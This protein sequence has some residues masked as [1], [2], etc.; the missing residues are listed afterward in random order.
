[1]KKACPYC[2]KIHE[3]SFVC[4]KKPQRFTQERGS[5]EDRFRWSYDWKLKREH[6]LRRDRYLCRA[7]LARLS[8]TVKPLN[9]KK[10]SVHHIRSLR[11][12]WE[13]RLAD[14]NLISLCRYHHKAAESGEL[15]A[16]D[17]LRLVTG[18]PPGGSAENQEKPLSNDAPLCK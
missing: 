6:I 4:E 14:E 10:L 7:C 11:T 3:K 16:A 18:G 12:N 17:L 2:G 8:G 13:L 9:N 1:M 15:R 5:R